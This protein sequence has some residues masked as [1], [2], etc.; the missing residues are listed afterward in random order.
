M[1][2]SSYQ[3]EYSDVIYPRWPQ[4]V[5]E[6]V[7]M[8]RKDLPLRSA[9]DLVGKKSAWVKDYHFEQFLPDSIEFSEVRSVALGLRNLERGRIDFFLDY[10]ETVNDTASEMGQD[11]SAFNMTPVKELAKPVYPMFRDDERGAQLSS[12]YNER[13][14]QLHKD[15]SLDRIFAKYE[16]GKYPTPQ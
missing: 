16:K 11:L 2:L 7:A 13:M 5:E 14:S 10:A 1:A 12:I 9:R 15:G 6:V 4:E 3:N 8:H